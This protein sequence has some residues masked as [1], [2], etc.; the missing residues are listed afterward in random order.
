MKY[1]VDC[2][3]VCYGTIEIEAESEKE[4]RE[5]AIDTPL[6]EFDVSYDIDCFQVENVTKEGEEA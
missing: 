4:A 1:F 2:S 3:W 5:I 6:D